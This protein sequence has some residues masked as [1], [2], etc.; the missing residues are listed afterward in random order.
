MRDNDYEGLNHR[1][2]LL[3]ISLQGA[4][5]TV[6]L[7]IES[8]FGLCPFPYQKMKYL[9]LALSLLVTC[10]CLEINV[11]DASLKTNYDG[12]VGDGLPPN[13]YLYHVPKVCDMHMIPD[14]SRVLDAP[15]AMW[16]T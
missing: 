11:T 13:L 12:T 9:V 7:H 14:F 6:D 15:H 4:A 1:L 8:A 3:A 10:E 5:R 2:S 16:G